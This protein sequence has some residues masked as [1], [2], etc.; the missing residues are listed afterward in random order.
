MFAVSII[1]RFFSW[2][3]KK[4]AAENKQDSTNI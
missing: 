4:E 2:Q 1:F 3:Q